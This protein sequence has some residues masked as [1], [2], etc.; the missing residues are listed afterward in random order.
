MIDSL[1]KCGFSILFV[2]AIVL[3]GVYRL[4]V[5][6]PE[7]VFRIPA[8]TWNALPRGHRFFRRLAGGCV[9]RSDWPNHFRS[10]IYGYGMQGISV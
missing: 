1:M 10:R 3:F 2:A 9:S 6:G 8:P 5:T 7:R 4:V